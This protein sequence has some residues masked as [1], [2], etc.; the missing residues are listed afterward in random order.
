MHGL[1]LYL[2]RVKVF[3]LKW[4]FNLCGGKSGEKSVACI[5]S[6]AAHSCGRK[7]LHISIYQILQ[8]HSFLVWPVHLLNLTQSQN[9]NRHFPITEYQIYDKPRHE[10]SVFKEVGRE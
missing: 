4:S 8:L 3:F 1:F 9:E 10:N 5:R 2:V 6:D 7:G